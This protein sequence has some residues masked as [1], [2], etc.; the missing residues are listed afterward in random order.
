MPYAIELYYLC[1]RLYGIFGVLYGIRIITPNPL[2][3]DGLSLGSSGF[4]LHLSE[5]LFYFSCDIGRIRNIVIFHYRRKRHRG[6][7]GTDTLDRGVKKIKSL[8]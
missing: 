4:K 8:P 3:G 2:T 5:H 1:K 7:R 6:I